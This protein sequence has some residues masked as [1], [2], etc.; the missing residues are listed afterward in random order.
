MEEQADDGCDIDGNF[1][2]EAHDVLC[3]EDSFEGDKVVE[4]SPKGRFS[5]FNR[6]LGAG[7]S[8]VVYLA[9]DNDT[10]REVAWNVVSVARLSKSDRKRLEGE[11]RVLSS[12]NHPRVIKFVSAWMN[13]S[14]NE[15]VFITEMV[16]GGSLRSYIM[17]I[18]GPLKLKVIRHWCI[19]I[20]EG[21]VYLHSKSIIHRDLKCDNIFVHGNEGNIVIADLGL[22]TVVS[23]SEDSP[24]YTIVGTPEFMAPELYQ[25]SS[26][27]SPI[28]IYAFG[29]CLLELVTRRSPYSSDCTTPGQVYRKVVS[30]ELPGS[31]A[32]IKDFQLA[33]IVK[34]CLVSDPSMRPTAFELRNDPFWLSADRGDEF[35]DLLL[36]GES[37]Q[38]V[39][40]DKTAACTP[41][42]ECDELETIHRKQS[43]SFPASTGLTEDVVSAIPETSQVEAAC[44]MLNLYRID[45]VKLRLSVGVVAFDY[46]VMVDTPGEIAEQL[47]ASGL[48]CHNDSDALILLINEALLVRLDEIAKEMSVEFSVIPPSS[49]GA[50]S[51]CYTK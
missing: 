22:S 20:L 27:G 32:L 8:K 50:S 16:S 26:Y 3:H 5:R 48:V 45:N 44:R 47:V 2:D 6:R 29:M 18:D 19:Q 31:V 30:G 21:I 15:L 13:R 9:F 14:R 24:H 39:V 11:V 7:S 40:T 43:V 17:R 4:R 28:D 41:R 36:N 38:K 25:E 12:L 34:S 42:A 46:I 33:E 51:T 23:A 49:A 37:M 1:G 10:G 35:A